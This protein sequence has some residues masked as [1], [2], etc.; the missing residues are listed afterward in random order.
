MMVDA[1]LSSGFA[2]K[3]TALELLLDAP[4]LVRGEVLDNTPCS[5]SLLPSVRGSTQGH[6]QCGSKPGTQLSLLRG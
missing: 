5:R 2:T 4:A 6:S 1:E 3:A